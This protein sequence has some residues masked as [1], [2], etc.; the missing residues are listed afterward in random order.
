MNEEILM[1]ASC[2][3][4]SWIRKALHADDKDGKESMHESSEMVTGLRGT[5][6]YEARTRQCNML[7]LS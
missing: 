6:I 7:R 2:W 5:N 1:D 4:N 3:R